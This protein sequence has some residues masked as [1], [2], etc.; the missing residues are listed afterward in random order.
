MGIGWIDQ[1]FTDL[2]TFD[3]SR[4]NLGWDN[5]Y[6]SRDFFNYSFALEQTFWEGKG[7]FSIEYDFQ[8]LYRDSYTALNGGNSVITFDVNETIL[9]PEDPNYAESGN[10]NAMPNPNFGARSS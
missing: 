6:Y 9:L 3:F 8:D 4:N 10:Y 1:G 7:G 5:D 2:E